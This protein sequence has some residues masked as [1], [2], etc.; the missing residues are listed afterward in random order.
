MFLATIRYIVLALSILVA[1]QAVGTT[2]QIISGWPTRSERITLM[3]P[4]FAPDGVLIDLWAYFWWAWSAAFA[5]LG[6]FCYRRI[7]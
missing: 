4:P 1:V 6:L 3:K 2:H 5:L 7:W